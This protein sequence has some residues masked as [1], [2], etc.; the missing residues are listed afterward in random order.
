[1]SPRQTFANLAPQKR[2]RI[3]R[4]AVE[5]FSDKGYQGA[6][7]NALVHRLGIAKGSIFQYFGDKEGLFLFVFNEAV[8]KVKAYLRRVREETIDESVFVRLEKTL[9]AGIDFIRKHPR[10]YALYLKVLFD[11]EMPLREEMLSSLR[12]HSLQYLQSLLAAGRERGELREDLDLQRC[13]FIIDAVME[14]FL[15]AYAIRHLDGEKGLYQADEA[16]VQAWITDLM[17][18]LRRGIG[19][20]RDQQ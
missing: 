10:L 8:E 16:G 19:A 17:A 20:A 15:Q 5:E 13:S 3:T 11:A 9:V 1:M 7:I 4:A 2:D 14:R 12:H 6:S 18:F